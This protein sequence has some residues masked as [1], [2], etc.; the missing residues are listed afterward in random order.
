MRNLL[1]TI[2]RLIFSIICAGVTYF[3]WMAIFLL[4]K[5][6]TGP[7]VKGVLWFMGPVITAAG[8]AIGLVI[9]EYIT[10]FQ[11]RSFLWT[12]LWPLVGC[13]LGAVAVYWYGPMLI[14][15]GMFA[16]GTLSIILRELFLRK[17]IMTLN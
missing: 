6:V 8:F 5:D 17:K 4:S 13:S 14:V 15:F 12:F 11:R 9:H 7:I 10:G 1:R 2:I 16:V 3:V